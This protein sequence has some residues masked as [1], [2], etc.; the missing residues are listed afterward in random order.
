V[1]NRGEGPDIALLY[2]LFINIRDESFVV[3]SFGLG[4]SWSYKEG[5]QDSVDLAVELGGDSPGV[6]LSYTFQF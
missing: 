4:L 1:G 3:F 6:A 5:T 2:Q